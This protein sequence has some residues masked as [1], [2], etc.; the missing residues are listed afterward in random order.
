MKSEKTI[1]ILITLFGIFS[2]FF[3]FF[4]ID[5]SL[6][7][8]FQQTAWRSGKLFLNDH[9]NFA[10]GPGEYVALIISQFFYIKWAGSLII[11]ATI[12]LIS[13]FVFLTLKKE[14]KGSHF[15]LLF[16]PLLQIL[17]LAL[18]SDYHFPFSVTFNLFFVSFIIYLSALIKDRLRMKIATDSIIAGIIVYYIS[19]GF[20]FLIF[21]M[22]S[23][24]LSLKKPFRNVIL[25][26]ALI[27]TATL[28]LPYL[29]YKFIFLLS[30]YGSYIRST[31]DLAVMLRYTKTPLFY[32]TLAAIPVFILFY[33]LS[34]VKLF[35]NREKLDKNKKGQIQNQ[36]V[37]FISSVK[38]QFL[39]ISFILIS[40]ASISFFVLNSSFRPD[41]KIK[42]QIDYYAY[43]Q[44]WDKVIELSGKVKEYDRMVNFHF[45]RAL[46]QK[47][48]MLEK[49]FS[50]EQ[51]LGTQGLFLDRPFAAEITLPNSDLYYELGNI[52]ESLRL[53]FEAQ[54]LMPESPR[55]LKRL[56]LNCI[57]LGNEKAALTYLNALGEIPVEKKW[58]QKYR[59]MIDEPGA[60]YEDEI[61][62][63]R[64]ELYKTEGIRV[65]PRTKLLALL[66]HNPENKAAFEYLVAF[67]L[68]EHDLNAFLDDLELLPRFQYDKLPLLI[69][70][71]I[72]LYGSQRPNIQ[73]LFRYNV[74]SSTLDRFRKFVSATNANKGNREKA[75]QATGEFRDT[76]WYYVLFLSPYV[77]NI[78]VETNPVD[79]NY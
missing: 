34:G 21:M 41:E 12:S 35:L 36:T 46:C 53:A 71:A 28:L 59:T 60:I 44:D 38:K 9:L 19:G 76:Y 10:G 57:I 79:V 6:Q 13:F 64:N 49:L 26:S 58:V 37:S 18:I 8:H 65:T 24:F 72:I 4:G 67:D 14:G 39:A 1:V 17:L 40:L 48:Q 27:L 55:V 31:P 54:T 5:I 32:A 45:N 3:L 47:G 42:L 63:K 78:R 23:L 43:N 66:E 30:L 70:E 20:Y 7:H 74:S 15:I 25:N 29:A 51:I 69:E 68:M 61:V 22:S 11:T 52:D 77:T 2:F 33:K 62:N 73:S 50:Y 56:I 75:K 16:L